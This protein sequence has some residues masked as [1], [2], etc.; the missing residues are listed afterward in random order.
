MCDV[1]L[2]LPAEPISISSGS[3]DSDTTPS[4]TFPNDWDPD[5]VSVI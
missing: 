3:C 2:D 1:T 5:V 4:D